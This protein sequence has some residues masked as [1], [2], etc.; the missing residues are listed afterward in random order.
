MSGLAK[1]LSSLDQYI[2]APTTL[3]DARI[4][5]ARNNYTAA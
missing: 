3:A 4:L 1:T 2:A 5:S